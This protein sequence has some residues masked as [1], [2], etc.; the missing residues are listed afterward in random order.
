MLAVGAPEP[1]DRGADAVDVDGLGAQPGDRELVEVARHHDARLRRAE[2][3]ELG[4]DLPGQHPEV[5]ES[6]RTA[7]SWGPAASTALAT[8]WVMS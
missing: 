7:P 2:L 6:M 8:P 4:A 3:V 1:V 5:A